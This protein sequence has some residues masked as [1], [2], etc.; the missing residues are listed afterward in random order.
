MS[1]K[2]MGRSSSVAF[3]I[4]HLASLVLSTVVLAQNDGDVKVLPPGTTTLHIEQESGSGRPMRYSVSL[5][6]PAQHLLHVRMQLPPGASM[7]ELQLPVWNALYQVRDFAQYVNWIRAATSSGRVLPITQ[8][9]KS[10]WR[11]AG[12]EDGAVVEYE[13]YANSSGPF[14][15]QLNSR[16]CFLNLAE[17]LMYSDDLRQEKIILD[18]D[19]LPERWRLASTLPLVSA[20]TLRADNY[21]QLVDSPVEIGQFNEVDF[22]DG[23]ARYRVI[24]DAEAS[25]YDMDKLTAMV[26]K[27]VAAETSWMKDRPFDTYTFIYHFP[28]GAGSGMEHA[29]GT[30][31]DVSAETMAGGYGSVAAITAH[32][33]FHLWNVKRIR[34]EAL[35]PPDYTRENYTRALWFSEGVT[36]TVEWIGLL[37]SGLIEEGEYRRE[38]AAAI[39]EL[40][41][42]SAHRTQSAEESSLDAWLE[43]DTYYWRP[44]RSISYYNKGELLGVLLDLAV[45]EASQ[46]R[47]SLREVFLWM[48]DNYA[49]KSRGFAESDGVRQAAEAVSGADLRWFFDK[50]VAGTEDV[51]W[52]VFFRT[53]G[54]RLEESKRTMP[55]AGFAAWRNFDGPLVVGAV[56]PGGPAEQAGLREGDQILA[57]NGHNSED[58]PGAEISAM[59]PGQEIVI[60]LSGDSGRARELKWKI[61]GREDK[62]YE[63]KDEENVT[64]SQL[65]RRS[66]WLKGEAETGD[67][68]R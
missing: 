27:V 55:D 65:A 44:D 53:V 5:F 15:A 7:R 18:F 49:R 4:T 63:L 16:H 39:G 61:G 30:A 1:V 8:V 62:V 26:R 35:E 54:L 31:I 40:Q 23:G 36:S 67:A 22:T 21:D 42:R 19:A 12:A 51:P 37:R 45:R 3:C 34:P 56:V 10:R 68:G 33:F 64:P 41:H 50:Y 52:N 48:N 14:G 58:S 28:H 17:I 46:G 43:G 2:R 60:R 66:A 20:W 32:E 24:V 25:T 47:A 9:N 29:C 57:V 38:L 11:L 59:K 6:N 13:V